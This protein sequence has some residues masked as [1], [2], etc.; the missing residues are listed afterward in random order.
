M[1]SRELIEGRNPN[2]ILVRDF[3]ESAAHQLK[4]GG[5]VYISAVDSPHY[6][7]AFQF[8]EAAKTAGFGPPEV[9][10]FDPK[11]FPGYTHTMTHEDESALDNHDKFATWVFEL[12]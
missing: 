6:Y 2:F 9:Y 10:P 1:A 5:K 7:G 4:P 3:L 8:D 11:D 12:A